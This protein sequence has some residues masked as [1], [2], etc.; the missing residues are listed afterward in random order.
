[1]KLAAGTY[2]AVNF[3]MGNSLW[4]VTPQNTIIVFDVP[5]SN[6]VSLTIRNAMRLQ[7][8]I[9]NKPITFLIYTIFQGDHTFGAQV[10]SLGY[11]Y[12]HSADSDTAVRSLLSN[13]DFVMHLECL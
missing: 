1:M 6:E 13:V 8:E 10:C 7:P 12:Y 3:A 5:E 9:G 11:C 4:V 2:M